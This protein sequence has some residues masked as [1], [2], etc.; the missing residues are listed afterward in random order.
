LDKQARILDV[1]LNT[2]IRMTAT[3]NKAASLLGEGATTTAKL[4][5]LIPDK[6][7]KTGEMKL[8]KTK[9]SMMQHNTTITVD[10][11][12]MASDEL[13]E[14]IDGQTKDSKIIYVGDCCQLKP[15]GSKHSPVFDAGYPTVSLHEPVR[16][17]PDSSLYKLCHQLRGIVQGDSLAPM[18]KGEGIHYLTPVEAAKKAK[19]LFHLGMST[20]SALIICYQNKQVKA[21]N[22]YIRDFLGNTGEWKVGEMLTVRNFVTNPYTKKAVSPAEYKIVVEDVSQTDNDNVYLVTAGT[23]EEYQVYR[24]DIAVAIKWAARN[25]DWPK[26]FSLKEHYAD[27][28]CAYAGTIF[29]AQGSSYDDVIIDLTDLATCYD[30]DTFRRMLY[31]SVSRAR[32]NV[33]FTGSTRGTKYYK[34]MGV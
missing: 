1:K 17:H 8:K 16:Q 14:F 22:A 29:T 28:R 5:G 12:S 23:G 6:C 24:G 7:M 21:Y 13:I 20:D 11:A 27:L 32:K 31:T 4:L 2:T 18:V 9:K 34:L 30:E 3:T 25:K 15:V 10:E 33:Y 26:Y 19:E